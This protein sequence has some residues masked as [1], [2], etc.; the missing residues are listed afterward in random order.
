M[1]KKKVYG[2]INN[3]IET[4]KRARYERSEHRLGS[5]EPCSVS[6]LH[7]PTYGVR[8]KVKTKGGIIDLIMRKKGMKNW[9]DGV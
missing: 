9:H 1:E 7:S 8:P 2:E 3:M 4:E 5:L 6:E